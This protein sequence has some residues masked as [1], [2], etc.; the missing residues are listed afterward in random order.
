LLLPQLSQFASELT[1][2]PACEKSAPLRTVT[3]RFAASL[4]EVL[5]RVGFLTTLGVKIFYPTPQVQLNHFYIAVP[6]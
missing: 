4:S 6:T 1:P 2:H 5:G 3:S